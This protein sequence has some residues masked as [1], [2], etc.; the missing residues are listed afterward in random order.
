[1]REEN[2][3][4]EDADEDEDFLPVLFLID[5]SVPVCIDE[6]SSSYWGTKHNNT[7]RIIWGVG[8]PNSMCRRIQLRN[9]F[10]G[11]MAS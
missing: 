4:E 2:K 3:G 11:S 9:A 7:I 10:G 5:E 6:R 1:M 8:A